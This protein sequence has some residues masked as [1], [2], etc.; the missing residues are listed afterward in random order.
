MQL[1]QFKQQAGS[2]Y[3]LND[4][5]TEELL[6]VMGEEKKNV[7]ASTAGR[8]TGGNQHASKGQGAMSPDQLDQFFQAQESINQRVYQRA[9]TFLSPAQLD[10]LARFQTNQ[11]QMMRKGIGMMRKTLTPDTPSAATS[12]LGK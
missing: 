7:A 8:L 6:T 3:N 12:A 9:R 4:Q 10:T 2:D 11:L 5:Q 1:N